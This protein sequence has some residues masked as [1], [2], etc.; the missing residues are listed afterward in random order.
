MINKKQIFKDIFYWIAIFIFFIYCLY[1]FGSQYRINGND[2]R[3]EN[4]IKL[5]TVIAIITL[6]FEL[7]PT[8]MLFIDHKETIDII[9]LIMIIILIIF[10]V[11]SL[12]VRI[13]C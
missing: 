2:F 12:F 7:I 6:I 10:T 11:V 5:N 8:V 9:K 1:F 13:L 4:I 3:L